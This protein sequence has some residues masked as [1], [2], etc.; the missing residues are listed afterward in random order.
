[1]FR[2]GSIL[3]PCTQSRLEWHPPLKYNGSFGSQIRNDMT[4]RKNRLSASRYC[5]ANNYFIAGRRKGRAYQVF[6]LA[7]HCNV[8]VAAVCFF[9]RFWSGSQMIGSFTTI[10][11]WSSQR[12][13]IVRRWAISRMILTLLEA[14]NNPLQ[15]PIIG[16]LPEK[17]DD[18]SVIHDCIFRFRLLHCMDQSPSAMAASEQFNH[19][20]WLNKNSNSVVQCAHSLF[21]LGQWMH[22]QLE[23]TNSSKA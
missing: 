13:V 5:I 16:Q 15:I 11:L 20:L 14:S 9:K 17:P 22:F 1:M 6:S 4:L 19:V 3:K 18:C 7:R 12:V 2:N 21:V 8:S 23:V 10:N